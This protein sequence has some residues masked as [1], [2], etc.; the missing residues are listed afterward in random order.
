LKQQPFKYENTKEHLPKHEHELEI[1]DPIR[2]RGLHVGGS[3]LAEY[4]SG[5][6]R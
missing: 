4:G 3:N 1:I 2:G 5:N 6:G